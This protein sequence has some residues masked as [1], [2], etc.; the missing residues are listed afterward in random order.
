MNLQ[1]IKSEEDY[2]ILLEW[3]DSQFDLNLHPESNSG[4]QLQIALLLIKQYEDEHYA[5][6]ARDPIDRKIE[7]ERTRS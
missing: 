6:P 3:V 4:Q 5:I 2:E 1:I 7:D